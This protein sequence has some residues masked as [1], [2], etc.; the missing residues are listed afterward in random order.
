MVV[1]ERRKLI[2]D[3]YIDLRI[4]T[5]FSNLPFETYILL[6]YINLDL[7]CNLPLLGGGGE[8]GGRGSCGKKSA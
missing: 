4:D 1:Y 2:F 5:Y 6:M 3:K 7:V 8:R